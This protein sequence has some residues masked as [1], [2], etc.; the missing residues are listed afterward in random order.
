MKIFLTGGTGVI[1]TRAIPALVAVGH[2]VTAVARSSGKAGLVRS[3]GASPIEVDLFDA[4][5]V[6]AA[7]VGHEVVV[8]LATNIPPMSRAA[9]ASAW[10]TNDRLRTE[11]SRHLVDAALAAGACRYVQESIC[12]PYQ[13]QGDAWID[14]S[15]AVDH[16]GPFAS[17][18]V[19][20]SEAARFGAA[21]GDGVVLRF[22]QFY[23]PDSVHVRGFNALVR[24]RVNPFL[25]PPDS[26]SS[27][28]HAADAGSA[29]AAALAVPGGVYNVGDDEPVTRADAGRI[30]ADTLDV[31]PPKALPR[32]LLATTPA[33]AKL[34]M[35]SLR[36]SNRQ[37]REA[38]GWAP[39]HPSIRGSWPAD[40]R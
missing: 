17:A 25:G 9:R 26:Y 40:A 3:L 34:M 24:R 22:A 20:E 8:N 11:A 21:G 18:G 6:A 33:S 10:V 15:G 31:K 29:V 16:V 23:A 39:A 35:R 5:E 38:T 36:V 4:A 19:A 2:N 28:I 37:F 1:G 13:D 27:F 32:V 7:V 30:V 12:F 14:E